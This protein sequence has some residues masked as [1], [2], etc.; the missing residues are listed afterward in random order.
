MFDKTEKVD[1]NE[2]EK[3]EKSMEKGRTITPIAFIKT[4][5]TEKFGIPRQSGRA[6]SL[7]AEI[8]F[9]EKY[10]QAEALQGIEGFSH[11][12]LIFDFSE[13]EEKDFTPTVRPPRLGGNKRVGVFASRSPFRPNRLGLSCVKLE[14]I[15][16]TE[17]GAVL[18]VSG[19]DLL[20]GTP[21][22]DIKPYLPFCDAIEDAVG[23][24]ADKEKD[25]KL[26]VSFKESLLDKIPNDKQA[27]VLECLADDPRPSYQKDAQ[28]I[29]G[30][31]FAGFEIKFTVDKK[32]LT[33]L[34]VEK[35]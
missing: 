17:K 31:L 25:Y 19:A 18:V 30:M 20:D 1:Y 28:R 27:G 2:G 35:V 11:L 12:W 3:E 32:L 14:E 23:G 13:T 24:Y 26:T 21:I 29:Y 34:S 6:P 7:R 33:V 15:K 9:L 16:H 4:D 22:F 5:F 10:R 8:V